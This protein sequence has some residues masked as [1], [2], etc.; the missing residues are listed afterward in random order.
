MRLASLLLSLTVALG[1]PTH[2]SAAPSAPD[3]S[4]SVDT[5]RA[6]PHSETTSETTSDS[7]KEANAA[8]TVTRAEFGLFFPPSSGKKKFVSSRT[9]PWVPNQAYG[10]RLTLK[11]QPG[12]MRWREEFVLPAAPSTWGGAM[13]GVKQDVSADGKTSVKEGVL[14]DGENVLTNLWTVA[15]GDPKGKHVI[16]VYLDDKL[17]Q[18]FDFDVE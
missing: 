14:Q 5:R 7:A 11:R 6:A 16:R 13:F 15:E 1:L 17:V 9:V 8:P 18:T 10:W 2:A 3:A 4:K 12:Q